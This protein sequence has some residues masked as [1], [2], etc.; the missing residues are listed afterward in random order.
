VTVEANKRF[1]QAHPDRAKAI[2]QRYYGSLKD[3]QP[4]VGLVVVG[5]AVRRLLR[6]NA[7]NSLR[8][9]TGNV[10]YV[11]NIWNGLIRTPV[12]TMI[13]RLAKSG[14]YSAADAI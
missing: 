11:G 3:K 10:G 9:R 8:A 12:W 14:V 2:S 7:P 6:S 1:R 5:T 13:M 4:V